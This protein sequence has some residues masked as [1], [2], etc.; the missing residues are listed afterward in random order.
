MIDRGFRSI[1]MRRQAAGLWVGLVLV[2]LM[3]MAGAARAEDSSEAAI[4]QY[5]A[6]AALQN[7]SL[8]DLAAD[9]WQKFIK[10]YPADPRVDRAWHYLGICQLK[11]KQYPLAI[12][13]FQKCVTDYPQSEVLEGSYL[14]LGIAQYS[15][16]QAGTRSAYADAERTLAELLRRWPDGKSAPQALFYR[17]ESLYALGKPGEAAMEYARL[18]ASYPEHAFAPDALYALGVAQQENKQAD[19]AA[20]SFA[21]FLERYP[22][23]PL[24]AEVRLRHGDV[25]MAQG[26]V[27][28]AAQAYAGAVQPGSSVADQALLR[29]AAAVAA[30][31]QHAAA[32]ELYASVAVRF[33]QS[34]LVA[35]GW[36]GAARSYFALSQWDKV[37]QAAER[38]RADA[39]LA[40][41]CDHW[42]VRS[43]LKEGK[44]TD[45]LNAAQAV[46]KRSTDKEWM[47]Q[48]R[49]D[50]ADAVHEM[51]SRRKES[52][53]LYAKI[54]D[55]FPQSSVAAQA[56]YL[57]ALAALEVGDYA[58][59]VQRADAFLRQTAQGEYRADVLNILAEAELQR[60]NHAAAISRFDMLLSAYGT[61]PEAQRWHVRR[62]MATFLAKD[63]PATIAALEPLAG[64]MRSADNRA[65]ALLL[66]GSSQLELKNPSARQ[67]L[68]LALAVDAKW[69][70][71][72]EVLFA[73]AA[74]YREHNETSRA[75]EALDRLLRDYPQSKLIARARLRL[76]TYATAIGD[77]KRSAEQY[78]LA[79]ETGADDET[80]AA[81]WYGLAWARLKEGQLAPA[82]AAAG[83]V[84]TRFPKHPLAVRSRY[85]RAIARQ[86][87][88]KNQEA[89]DD[90]TAVLATPLV[91]SEKSDALYVLALAQQGL[92]KHAVAEQTL[93]ELLTSDPDYSDLDKALYE[94]AWARMY[95]DK[96]AEATDV[97]LKLASSRPKSPL[98]A[99]ALYH[100]ADFAYEK[101]DY[102]LA[103]ERF[104][105]ALPLAA[106][107]ELGEKILHKLGWAQFR[108]GAFAQAENCFVE[109]RKRFPNGPLAADAAF[110][111]AESLFKQDRFAEALAA[112][113]EVKT[114]TVKDA[115]ALALLHAVQ[116]AAHLKQW[117][118][119]QKR[120]DRAAREFAASAL[121]PEFLCEEAW[122]LQNQGKLEEAAKRY[123]Q[124][125]AKTN[126]ESAARAQFQIGKIQASQNKTTEAIK[127]YFKTAY[128][129]S[130]PRWQAEATYEAG[131]S[132]ESLRKVDQAVKQYQELVENFPASDKV[133]LARQ[134][135]EQLK[136]QPTSQ[137][138]T[139]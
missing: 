111:R 1:P 60:G 7:K 135:L 24:A 45:A 106:D 56:G 31:K 97:F 134:R 101:G 11:T 39:R 100:A 3:G 114:P 118:E 133:P 105:L 25:L 44:P 96:R 85:V 75:I 10:L 53:A 103:A 52:V 62:A 32:A 76:A 40:S 95:Q 17:A 87:E 74:A 92:K 33:P 28:A 117:E 57:A 136:S 73:L 6:A 35:A 79:A 130:Y 69:P 113:T 115:P 58:G 18:L 8:F 90:L 132:F 67:T 124:V 129:Y 81:A 139:P 126:K 83:E 16:G 43:Y 137:K 72:D 121:W 30:L 77:V 131:Q 61:Q 127:S 47:P 93:S 26:A 54:A 68:E 15:Q 59:A 91:K 22:E 122:M 34:P 82:A 108:N 65:E 119:C 86:Q 46:L 109:Q 78:R 23:S 5:R 21:R 48:L 112:Y 128:G 120:L 37:R 88:G 50:E 2:L 107:D 94:L 41:E 42:I 98:A 51:A 4:R 138:S 14:Y 116:A 9:E 29:Q 20:R 38:G 123:E 80:K 71:N 89:V 84:V 49:L 104:G 19:Q 36:L 66:I 102:R 70:R 110:M 99:E 63:Y 12:A 13:T 55:E 125:I 64:Q 27:A